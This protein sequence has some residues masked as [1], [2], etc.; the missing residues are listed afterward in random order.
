MEGR[1]HH[2]EGNSAA[3]VKAILVGSSIMVPVQAGSILLGRWQEVF[4]CEFDGP[5]TRIG[6]AHIS[7]GL[8]RAPGEGVPI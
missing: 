6:H 2:A 1:Y 3:H 5:R 8:R 4:F 7:P